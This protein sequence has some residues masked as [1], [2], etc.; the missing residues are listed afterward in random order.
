M[1][2]TLLFTSLC[3]ISTKVGKNNSRQQIMKKIH[4]KKH[5]LLAITMSVMLMMGCDLDA[6]LWNEHLFQDLCCNQLRD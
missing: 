2:E 1:P 3:A 4:Q 6:Q 5:K